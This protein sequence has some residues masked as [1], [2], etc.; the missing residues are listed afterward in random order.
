MEDDSEDVGEDESVL[1]V[2]L[3][4]NNQFQGFLVE[5]ILKAT[6]NINAYGNPKVRMI[7]INEQVDDF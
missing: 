1:G 7:G 4:A 2:S 3:A 5:Q 6:T